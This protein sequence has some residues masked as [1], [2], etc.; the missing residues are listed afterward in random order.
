MQRL[1]ACT[2]SVMSFGLV[3]APSTFV[4]QMVNV[5]RGLQWVELLLFM[6]DIISPCVTVADGLIR[7]ENI[8][9]RLQQANLKLK[10]SKCIFFQKQ[11]KFLGH[12]VS[13]T[14]IQTEPAKI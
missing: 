10:P 4:R 13:E 5:L 1:W 8:F 3:N 7:L 11:V 12:I 9:M 2:N 14:G 6:D